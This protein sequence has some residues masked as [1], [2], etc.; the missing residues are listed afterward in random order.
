[1]S[2]PAFSVYES[3]IQVYIRGLTSL[4][5]I[6]KK[7]QASPDA[8]S[9]PEARL[10]EDMLP[11]SFQV[12]FLSTI[13]ARTVER[14]AGDASGFQSA[15]D[16]KTLEDLIATAEKSLE[17]AKSIS[18][19]AVEG[20]EDKTAQIQVGPRGTITTTGRGYL[21]GW[22]LPN[23]FFHLTTA[24]NILR[25]KGV[26]VGKLDYLQSFIGPY[27]EPVPNKA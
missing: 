10:Y 2:S 7:A 27:G 12:Q 19:K 17:L 13:V 26:P 16:E 1:M 18:H 25:S 6:L 14:I 22:A 24:Y 21:F 23:F 9:F 4:V 20:T 11:L 8:A 15:K 3:S 5:G